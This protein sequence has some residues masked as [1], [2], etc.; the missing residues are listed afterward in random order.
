MSQS[1]PGPVLDPIDR[2]SEIVFGVLMALSFTGA[3]SVSTAGRQEIRT[4]L[5]TALGCNLAWGLVD[6]VMYLLRTATDRRRK[7]ALLVR[8][9]NTETEPE[10]H[11]LIQDALPQLIADVIRPPALQALHQS[12][13]AV[14]EPPHR[15]VFRDYSAAV[16]IF[17]L[18][19]LATFP[20]VVPFIFIPKIALALRVS[21]LLA[22]ATLYIGGAMLGRY[23]GGRPWVYGLA[24]SAIGVALL[25]VI[26]ALG[27]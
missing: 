6:A 2:V 21:N 9:R 25:S 7:K 15:L 11:R 13:L 5:F 26:I 8:L 18:V 16:G 20:V 10:A 1:E 14:H 3:L 4:L 19:V 23:A 24:L 17:L 22:I 27:G 12:L